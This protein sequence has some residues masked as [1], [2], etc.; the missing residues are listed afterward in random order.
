MRTLN[1][2]AGYMHAVFP[3]PLHQKSSQN[4]AGSIYA[5]FFRTRNHTTLLTLS[6]PQKKDDVTESMDRD[7]PKST[8]AQESAQILKMNW[9]PEFTRDLAFLAAPI[10]RSHAS[11]ASFRF[12]E[13]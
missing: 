1:F 10:E 7:S 2:E 8:R 9:P 12:G 13:G 3:K 5:P 6:G 11:F 4:R